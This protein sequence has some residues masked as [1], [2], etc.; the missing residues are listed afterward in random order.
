MRASA[1]QEG[2][3]ATFGTETADEPGTDGCNRRNAHR[4][5]SGASRL[6]VGRWRDGSAAPAWPPALM[7]YRTPPWKHGGPSGLTMAAP[8]TA[9]SAAP[10]RPRR[11]AAAR[12]LLRFAPERRLATLA[13]FTI[14]RQAALTGLAAETFDKRLCCEL[15]WASAGCGP[16][17]EGRGVAGPRAKPKRLIRPV[18]GLKGLRTVGAAT[19]GRGQA[20]AQAGSGACLHR[21]GRQP[22]RGR[23]RQTRARRRR[24]RACRGCPARQRTAGPERR[25]T[26]RPAR[27]NAPARL[28]QSS[29]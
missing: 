26:A 22:R 20:R 10:S 25:A 13:A 3:N 14:G 5:W 8:S 17:Y 16:S 21:R 4:P 1:C 12:E 6:P 29:Q 11:R 15:A 27:E 24:G 2:S 18:R 9:G 23:R 28:S 7:T 19:K